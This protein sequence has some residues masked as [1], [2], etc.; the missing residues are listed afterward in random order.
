MWQA[1]HNGLC[2][3]LAPIIVALL[4]PFARSRMSIPRL[5]LRPSQA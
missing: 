4:A 2:A 5:I 3:L 1:V